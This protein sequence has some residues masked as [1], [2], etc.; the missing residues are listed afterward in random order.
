MAGTINV[1]ELRQTAVTYDPVLRYL[2][3]AQL[4]PFISE[5]HFN[6]QTVTEE[7]RRINVRRA[8]NLLR[9]YKG[10]VDTIPDQELMHPEESVLTPRMGYLAL[11]DNIQNY[12]GKKLLMKE[13]KSLTGAKAEHPY[14]YEILQNVSKTFVEDFTLAIP[15]AKAGSDN[16]PLG[17]FDGYN[18]I[19]D[20]L[21]GA[22]KISEE[23]GN[24]IKADKIVAP[25]KDEEKLKPLETLIGWVRKLDPM[26]RGG[27]LDLLIPGNVLMLVLDSFEVRRS[28]QGDTSREKLAEYLRDKC[29]LSQ[30]PTIISNAIMGTGDRLIA[31]RPGNVTVGISAPADLEFIKVRDV[32]T[33]PNLVQFW[34][35]ADMGT[36]LDDWNRKVFATSGGTITQT[37]GLAGDYVAKKG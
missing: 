21:I 5:M 14:E 19:I 17:V 15:H 27:A 2:P 25:T 12:R 22:T 10:T 30:T 11:L 32:Y 13:G 20:N 36:R 29:G 9:P 18:A 23:N 34:M 6:L 4:S 28:Y 7:D 8:G 24:L 1:A 35:Q 3:H 31:M 33:D 16:S 37:A 26:L